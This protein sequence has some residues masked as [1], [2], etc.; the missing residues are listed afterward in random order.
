MFSDR[1]TGLDK[2]W[3]P[4]LISVFLVCHSICKFW[5][6][7]CKTKRCCSNFTIITAIFW[8]VRI[9]RI[10]MVDFTFQTAWKPD[11]IFLSHQAFPF[12]L[13]V[14]LP[15]IHPYLNDP[16]PSPTNSSVSQYRG[17]RGPP[18]PYPRNSLSSP[19]EEHVQKGFCNKQ[20]SITFNVASNL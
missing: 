15:L 16:S 3:R 17:R 6:Y 14:Q 4:S 9:F 2:Q 12:V 19:A 7:Y 1:Q 13:T 11:S 8:C 5:I 18:H 10:F 20:K